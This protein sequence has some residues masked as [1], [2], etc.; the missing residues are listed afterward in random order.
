MFRSREHSCGAGVDGVSSASWMTVAV[1]W[2]G[3]CSTRADF[4]LQTAFLFPNVKRES[5][6]MRKFDEIPTCV[7]MSVLKIR[8]EILLKQLKQNLSPID[9]A[10]A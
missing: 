6:K 3:T 8:T 7:L 5:R 2:A 10:V 4:N 9:E 1:L